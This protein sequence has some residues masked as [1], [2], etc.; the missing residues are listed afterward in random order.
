VSIQSTIKIE[1]RNRLYHDRFQYALS[2]SLDEIY[3]IREL[4]G[5]EK[6][7][8]WAD[9]RMIAQGNSN[10]PYYSRLTPESVQR[11]HD[12]QN[13][14]L[15][16][17]QPF[18]FTV[19]FNQAWVYTSDYSDLEHLYSFLRSG[20]KLL[21]WRIHGIRKAE[22][23]GDPNIINLKKSK[24]SSR[25]Y[26]KDRK[27]SEDLRIQL[28]AWLNNNANAVKPSMGLTR[29]L[30]KAR[31]WRSDYMQ[32]YFYI[33]CTDSSYHTLFA[34]TFPG[35]FRRAVPIVTK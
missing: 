29:W 22:V 25:V 33:D 17:E 15:G 19:S 21:H 2:F 35:V 9:R 12:T 26:F 11:L 27:V 7:Q 3:M 23:V 31:S 1:K 8:Y 28:D 4:P 6:L 24:Y 18:K 5:A 30:G 10:L 34:M 32:R 20:E 13:Q 14:L 16:F